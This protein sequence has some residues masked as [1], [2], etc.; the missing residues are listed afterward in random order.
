MLGEDELCD[1]RVPDITLRDGLE[2]GIPWD[3][4]ASTPTRI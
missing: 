4:H 3:G 2:L 1:G